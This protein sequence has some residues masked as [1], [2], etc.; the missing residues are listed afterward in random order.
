[1][2]HYCSNL[3]EFL[4]QIFGMAEFFMIII[5]LRGGNVF[6]IIVNYCFGVLNIWLVVG[7]RVGLRF[8]FFQ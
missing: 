8:R 3:K 2:F 5:E 4:K 6:I 1:M 7:C